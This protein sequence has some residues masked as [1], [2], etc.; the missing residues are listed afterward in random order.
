MRPA[1]TQTYE[2]AHQFISS[3]LSGYIF[4][5]LF[6]PTCDLHPTILDSIGGRLITR[7]IR[8]DAQLCLNLFELIKIQHGHACT[9]PAMGRPGLC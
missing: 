7:G 3:W 9:E 6:N 8:S 1:K 4:F 5:K 2:F